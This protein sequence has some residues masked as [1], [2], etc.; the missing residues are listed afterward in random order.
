MVCKKILSVILTVGM[1]S[2][3]MPNTVTAAR[4]DGQSFKVRETAAQK[5]KPGAVLLY[6]LRRENH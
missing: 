6:V 5:E 4:M 1:L 2:V 3:L